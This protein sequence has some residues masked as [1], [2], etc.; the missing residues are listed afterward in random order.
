VSHNTRDVAPA[1]GMLLLTRGELH[2]ASTDGLA[3]LARFLLG[4]AAPAGPWPTDGARRHALVLAIMRAE[5][6][7]ARAPRAHRHDLPAR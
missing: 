1:G 5:T 3:R 7:L 4:E 2:E 6:R